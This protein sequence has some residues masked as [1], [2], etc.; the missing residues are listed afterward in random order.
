MAVKQDTPAYRLLK[1]DGT[2]GGA[3]GVSLKGAS[4]DAH[5]PVL[6]FGIVEIEVA[7]G[8]TIAA[9]DLVTG[10]AE[11]KAVKLTGTPLTA[12]NGFCAA[13]APSSGGMVTVLLK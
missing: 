1:A 8:E 4:K 7:A 11:G 13:M 3:V 10:N 9:N 12:V 2:L 5:C 6:V